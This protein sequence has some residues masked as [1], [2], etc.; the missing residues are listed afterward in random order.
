MPGQCD[1]VDVKPVKILNET[2][3]P[4]HCSKHKDAEAVKNDFYHHLKQQLLKRHYVHDREK[5]Q[6]KKEVRQEYILSGLSNT[7]DSCGEVKR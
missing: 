6:R 1:C 3:G 5:W 4:F 2:M 7:G